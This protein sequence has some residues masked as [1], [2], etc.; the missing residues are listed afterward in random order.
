MIVTRLENLEHAGEKQQIDKLI[1]ATRGQSSLKSLKVKSGISSIQKLIDAAEK[2][3]KAKSNAEAAALV[4]QA[5]E[6]LLS[7]KVNKDQS[8]F[9]AALKNI[10]KA[11]S[12]LKKAFGLMG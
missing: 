9:D 5:E 2:R 12:L 1:T 8:L 6:Q 3:L 4:E 11:R 7:A 10:K